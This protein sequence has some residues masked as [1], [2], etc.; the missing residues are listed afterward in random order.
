MKNVGLEDLRYIQGVRETSQERVESS[1][2]NARYV[3]GSNAHAGAS[4]R[5]AK[6]AS[7]KCSAIERARPTR[8]AQTMS[9]ESGPSTSTPTRSHGAFDVALTGLVATLP[10]NIV[11]VTELRTPQALAMKK[12]KAVSALDISKY[13][14]L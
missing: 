10:Q 1:T 2:S 11:S 13:E 12:S 7:M 8:K 5:K 9:S 3:A 14:R 4:E 6:R